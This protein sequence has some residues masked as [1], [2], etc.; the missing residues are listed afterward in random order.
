MKIGIIGYGFVGKATSLFYHES[1]QYI[2]YDLDKTKCLPHNTTLKDIVR[3]DIIFIALPTPMNMDGSCDTSI[4]E[5]VLEKICHSNIVIRS[6]VPLGFCEKY[7]VYFMPEFL[8]EDN[9]KQDF[10]ENKHWVIGVPEKRQ[11]K[12]NLELEEIIQKSKESIFNSILYDNIIYLTSTEAE[13]VKLVKNTYLST[14]VSFFNEIYDLAMQRGIDY[15]NVVHVVGLDK[16]IGSSHMNV[17]NHGKRG[18]GGTCFPK[19]TNNIYSLFQESNLKSYI[20]ESNLKRNEFVDRQERDWLKD[21][22]TNTK[23]D[24]KI[25]L[26][27]GGAGFI[28]SNLCHRLIQDGNK[29]ICVDN[30]STGKLENIQD[31]I[32]HPNFVFKKHDI[33]KTLFL[34][35]VDEIYHLACPASPPQYQNNPLKTIKTS[36]KGMWNILKICKQQRCKLLFTSTSEIYGDPLEHPQKEE[37]WG[38]V[39]PIGTRSC[40]DESKRLCETIIYEY[41]KKH[42]LDLKIVRIFNTYGP[43]MDLNDGRIITNVIRAGIQNQSLTINGNGEQTRSFCYVDDMIEGLLKMMSSKEQGPI[44]LGN[45][46]CEFTINKLVTLYHEI[47]G[48]KLEI[49]YELYDKD[50]PKQRKPDIT[51]AKDNLGWEPKINLEEGLKRM[52]PNNSF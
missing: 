17:P 21:N 25:I 49:K 38:N 15:Q 18:Y 24:G 31:L 34:P 2:I 28:G 5:N 13:L 44:N 45:P 32:N 19:D 9:W 43:N 6:T 11:Q 22:R 47:S 26:V 10:I 3:C 1:F 48:N 37:Y 51:K 14:K 41:R 36:I 29:V 42:N 23:V 35:R 7:D 16:R 33:T 40:Y 20:L 50:D 27:T 4:I 8:T 46:T 52:I 39:N 30:L 12:R